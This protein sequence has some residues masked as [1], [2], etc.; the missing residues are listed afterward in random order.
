MTEMKEFEILLLSAL[1]HDIGKFAQ[2]A[3]ELPEGYENFDEKDYGEHGAHSKW[4]ASFVEKYLPEVF[5]EIIFPIL[6]HHNPKDKLSAILK[7]ADHLSS[8]E[9][10][11]RDYG[12]PK[13]LRL[14]PVLGRIFRPEYS[15]KGFPLR[16]VSLNKDD[17]FPLLPANSSELTTEY[18]EL[19]KLFKKEIVN[20]KNQE[21]SFRTLFESLYY[22]LYKYTWCIPSAAYKSEPD[23][24][25]FDHLKLTSAIAAVIFK[26][27]NEGKFRLI[28]GDISGIQ[29]FIY[30]LASPDEAQSGMAQRLRGRS[31]Y[32][33]LL[34]ETIATYI[35]AKLELYLVNLLWCGG[36]NFII[37]ADCGEDI[38]E[39]I[40]VIEQW[41]LEKYNGDIGLVISSIDFDKSGLLNFGD[42]LN[43]LAYSIHK[44]KL[45]KFSTIN[46][47]EPFELF[48]NVC[49]VCG[50]D[51]L[52]DICADCDNHEKIGQ[53]IPYSKFLVKAPPNVTFNQ[54]IVTIPFEKFGLKWG[55]ASNIEDIPAE[56]YVIYSINNSKVPIHKVSSNTS[57]GFKFLA[58]KVPMENGKILTF[59]DMQEKSKGAKFLASL[60]MDVDDLG[61]AFAFGLGNSK[62]PSRIA[63]LSRS[64]EMFFSGYINTITEDFESVY[65]LYS[66]GDDLFIVSSWNEAIQ[67]AKKIYD[68]FKEFSGL[69]PRISI[70]GGI[71]IFKHKFP[72]GMAATNSKERLEGLAKLNKAN[73]KEKD[74]LAVF[75]FSCFWEEV[76]KALDFA[77]WLIQKIEGNE[78]SHHFIYNI[79]QIYHSHFEGDKE[80]ITWIPKFLY[81]LKR[82]I[83]NTPK[84]EKSNELSSK[85][86]RE[87][88]QLIKTT[89]IWANYVL[90]A[91]RK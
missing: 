37:L 49:K 23:I 54:F 64:L 73:G 19:W 31:F 17:I 81:H 9:R 60:R 85:L 40:Q 21:T 84:M 7:E 90:L 53:K 83:P 78:I 2:R 80:D 45:K 74:S 46:W 79:L 87:M 25:L 20:L 76:T 77:E 52:T 22:I 36:G 28:G 82:N 18:A 63:S 15:E 62:S 11:S 69:D 38:K 61:V 30:K 55:L 3:G 26:S 6:Y 13:K 59:T 1:L 68:E 34:N 47:P 4:S 43:Q 86:I 41:M 75:E 58:K 50:K 12:D 32:L 33:S 24:S 67:C 42:T 56:S 16:P 65:I 8:G 5:K 57:V 39:L 91:T 35:L 89:P 29:N 66:G 71:Y 44:E 10:I 88:P 70:S 72:I 51:S 48:G 27:N 14:I